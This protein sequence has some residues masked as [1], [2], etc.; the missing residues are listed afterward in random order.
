MAFNDE[1]EANELVI[2]DV[3]LTLITKR[4]AVTIFMAE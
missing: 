3:N 1:P 2:D 4:Y